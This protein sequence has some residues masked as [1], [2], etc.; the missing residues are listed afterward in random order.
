MTTKFDELMLDPEFKKLYA[1]EHL[2]ADTAQMLSDLLQ[3]RN[4]KKADL[5]RMLNK[6]PAFVSQLLNGKANMTIRTLAEVIHA[7]GAHVM[8]DAAN[9]EISACEGQASPGTHTFLLSKT[10]VV[11]PK[12]CYLFDFENIGNLRGGSATVESLE[13]RTEYVA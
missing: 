9:E 11:P 2:I 7:L 10:N 5:A 3:R 1:V 4:L 12:R 6:T 13:I 8:I